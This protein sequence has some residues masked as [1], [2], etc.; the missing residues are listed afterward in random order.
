MLLFAASMDGQGAIAMQ[1]GR[2]Y[3]RLTGNTIYRLLTLVRFGRFTEILEITERPEGEFEAGVWDFAQGYAELRKGDPRFAQPY[4][5]RLLAAMDTEEKFRFHPAK[6]LLAVLAGILE[7]EIYRHDGD[8]T[9]AITTLQK[10]V[11]L[12]DALVY[13]EPEPIPFAA[14]HWLG[15]ALLEAKRYDEAEQVYRHELADHP[16]N[17]WSLLGLQQALEAQGKSDPDV[18]ADFDASWARSDTWIRGSRL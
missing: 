3:A 1:A 4:L 10:A 5:D 8:L 15:A 7:G 17:G 9:A 6:D 12:D 18:D 11:E 13:D 2:D 14:G 16:H